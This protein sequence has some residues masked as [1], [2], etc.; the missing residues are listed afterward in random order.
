VRLAP[1]A[2]DT[3]RLASSHSDLW[4]EIMLLNRD[5]LLQA[6]R[7][8]E[9]PLGELERAS[10][11]GDAPYVAACLTRTADCRPKLEP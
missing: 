9:E 5:H 7:S 10:E 8:L 11:A 2:R 6:L 3:T 4:T 1:G